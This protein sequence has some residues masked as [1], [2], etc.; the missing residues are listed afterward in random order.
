VEASESN[1]R[2]VRA[3]RR[4][5]MAD[6]L[7]QTFLSLRNRNFLLFFVG[8]SISNTGNW[9]T[10]VALTLLTLRITGSGVAV[11]FLAACQYGPILV[12]SVWG[13]AIADRSDKRRLLFATQSLEMGQSIGLA[14]LAF[15]THPPLA[16]LYVLA[17][18][19]GILLSLDNPLRR[20]FV[21]EMVRPEDIPNAVVLYSM[22]VN[23]SR[24]FGPALAGLLITT[25]GYGWCFAV[26]AATYL[27]VLLCLTLMRPE[28]LYRAL[29][30]GSGN[31]DVREG[32]RYLRSMPALW[33]TFVMLAGIG[34][35]AYNFNVTLPLFVKQALHG[36]D[37]QFTTVYSVL[38]A[39][40]LLCGLVVARR[41]FVT[42][43]QVVIGAGV[44]GVVML[45][46]S[47]S[48]SFIV[49][50]AIAF[51][52]GAASIFYTTTT[53]AI[54]QVTA[55]PD[56]HGRLLA[57]QT[58]L[59]VGSS[60]FGGPISGWLADAFGARYLMVIGGVVCLL[61]AGFGLATTLAA[62]SVA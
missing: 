56:M 1:G 30:H 5:R 21:T 36:S 7:G 25:L 43:R 40:G 41:G 34:T 9:L 6:A 55:R 54:V 42:L 35:L 11:G 27:A 8:Q 4:A 22:I 20:S 24:I 18:V 37:S 39:G 33:I 32:F 45:L 26:D 16:G 52:L 47:A 31:R 2:P 3:G 29:A 50:V 19:G 58:V 49:A 38:S 51:V 46:F 15:L 23:L 17:V 10:N 28:E 44:F 13:G 57:L 14:I 61:A 53:T 60:A 48:P 59:L 62:P 12:L